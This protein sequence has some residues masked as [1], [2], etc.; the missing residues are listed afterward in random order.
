M[1]VVLNDFNIAGGI[2]NCD[3]RFMSVLSNEVHGYIVHLVKQPV[4]QVD[5]WIWR[6]IYDTSSKLASGQVGLH[7]QVSEEGLL[8]AIQAMGPPNVPLYYSMSDQEL[9]QEM[10]RRNCA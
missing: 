5:H 10:K 3:T 4:N 7:A 1:K 9:E 8:R 2:V 6:F